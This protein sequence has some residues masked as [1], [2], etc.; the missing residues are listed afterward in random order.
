MEAQEI[1]ATL[2]ELEN[3]LD[4][5]RALYEQ[6][7]LGIEKIEPSVARKDVDRR[8]WLLRKTQIRNTAR[9]FRLQT[10]TQR[11]NTFQQHWTR[12]CREIENGTYVRHLLKVKKNF[13]EEPKTW[14][15]RKRLGL[16]RKGAGEEAEAAEETAEAAGAEPAEERDL[17]G[18]LTGGDLD[19]EVLAATAAAFEHAERPRA[20]R[21]AAQERFSLDDLGPLNLDFDDDGQP[22]LPPKAAPAPALPKPAKPEPSPPTT[23]VAAGVKVP[24]FPPPVPI[25]AAPKPAA[26]GARPPLPGRPAIPGAPRVPSALAAPPA[27]PAEP[28]PPAPSSPTSSPP[29]PPRPKLP[30]VAGARPPLPSFNGAPLPA[31]PPIPGASP[32][33][34]PIPGASPAPRPPLPGGSPAA[35]PPLPGAR[36]PQAGA[37]AGTAP[38]QRPVAPGGAAAP[39]PATPGPNPAPA[40]RPAAPAPNP[41]AARPADPRPNPAP[42]VAARPADPRPNPA[43]AAKDLSDDRLKQLH[44]ELI[45]TKKKLNLDSS[46]SYDSLS[47]SL[48]D[49]ERKLR[50]EHQGRSVDF[51]VVVKDG[52]A[53]VKPIVRK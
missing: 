37:P 44:R 10:L 14:A 13:G 38:V 29:P 46:L 28:F 17:A 41:A 30:S 48:R 40:A 31:R 24:T 50:A 11:Y 1:D 49:T 5:L 8:F 34:P 47:K 25:G 51:Q 43:A 16:L 42:A 27:P 26:A 2:D 35:R 19:A 4:R 9:R 20:P 36:P 21:P 18:M 52:K 12:I 45:E 53:V 32:A 15:A 7:F 3:R 6:Y 22:T 39:R 33:R 23:A